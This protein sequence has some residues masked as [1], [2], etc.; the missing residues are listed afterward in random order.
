MP[1]GAAAKDFCRGVCFPECTPELFLASNTL[2]SLPQKPIF[3]V[4]Q[5]SQWVLADIAPENCDVEGTD[6]RATIWMN[7]LYKTS[8]LSGI[9]LVAIEKLHRKKWNS[10]EDFVFNRSWKQWTDAHL[11]KLSPGKKKLFRKDWVQSTWVGLQ[12]SCV[13]HQQT[14]SELYWGSSHHCNWLSCKNKPHDNRFQIKFPS[15]NISQKLHLLPNT[16]QGNNKSQLEIHRCLWTHNIFVSVT[17]R[18]KL[19]KLYLQAK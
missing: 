3:Q 8:A 2:I 13:Y 4:Q 12:T 16:A 9:V 18:I 1:A 19:Y 17:T 14:K 5:A 11:V 6:V 10:V 7:H 15:K